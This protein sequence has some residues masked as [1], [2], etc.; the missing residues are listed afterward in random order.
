MHEMP[1]VLGGLYGDICEIFLHVIRPFGPK[2]SVVFTLQDIGRHIDGGERRH[3][4]ID[5][6]LAIIGDSPV[7][8]KSTLQVARRHEVI[9][10]GI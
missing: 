8:I 5:D 7:P 2:D 4:V 9:H 3:T 1:R 6:L 10:P